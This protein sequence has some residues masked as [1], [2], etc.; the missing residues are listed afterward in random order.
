M[1][2]VDD[3]NRIYKEPGHS[4]DGP[5]SKNR[6]LLFYVGLILVSL[7]LVFG[8]TTYLILTGLTPIQPRHSVVVTVLLINS[9]LIG[10]MILLIAWHVIELWINFRS[11]KA[12]SKLHVRFVSQFSLVAALPAILLAIFASISLDRGLDHLFSTHTKALVRDSLEVATTYIKEHSE[13]IRADMIAV[14]AAAEKRL[15]KIGRRPKRLAKMLRFQSALRALPS[16][17]LIRKNGKL[18]AKGGSAPD[19]YQKPQAGSLGAAQDGTVIIIPPTKTNKIGAI[20]KLFKS[21]DIYLYALRPVNPKVIRH[22][23]RAQANVSEYKELEQ[24]RAGVQIAFALTYVAIALTLL[25]AAIWLGLWFANR[26]SDPIRRLIVAAQNVQQGDLETVINLQSHHG[27]LAQ[28]GSTFNNMTAELKSNQ[29]ELIDTNLMLEERRRFIEAVLYGVS[30]GVIGLDAFGI[31]DH[32]N[33]SAEQMLGRSGE[34]LNGKRLEIAVPEFLPSITMAKQDPDGSD[35]LIQDDIDMSV[36]GVERHFAVRLTRESSIDH[37]YGFVL[38]FDD[39]TELVKAQRSSAWADVA[40]RIAHEMKNP[41]TPIQLS[42]ERIRRKYE[43]I[44]GNDRKVLD[45]CTDTIIGRV[46]DIKRMVDEFSDYARMPE[47]VMELYD[48]R[49]IIHEV[50]TLYENSKQKVSLAV[51]VPDSPVISLCDKGLISQ[52]LINLVKNATE[53]VVC[54]YERK[55]LLKTYQGHIEIGLKGGNNNYRITVTDNGCGLPKEQRN[56]LLEPYMTT[57][58]KGTGLG[59]AIVQKITEQ[60]DGHIMLEDAPATKKNKS[61][62]R[63]RLVIPY[64]KK[65]RSKVKPTTISVTTKSLGIGDKNSDT[66]PRIEGENYG[67]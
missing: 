5:F 10:G 2:S 65:N 42:A 28:L 47:P 60:H 53:A 44:I 36:N 32:V 16:L 56:R 55:P 63:V 54:A 30:A 20:K 8:I 17:Y 40:Q 15:P 64:K 1:T 39:T 43:K 59:L 3:T 23:Q 19:A 24:R 52:A 9:F 31:V 6:K 22:F 29:N 67:V 50:A 46:A 41:L 35:T 13:V 49:D 18:I 37:E 33:R 14:A 48:I 11:G 27:E 25:L 26:L 51:S 66:D 57:R 12:G 4:A 38:T 61:G 7:S 45:D 21:A 58:D 34:E 62:A